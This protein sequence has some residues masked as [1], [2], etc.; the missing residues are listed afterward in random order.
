MHQIK[1]KKSSHPRVKNWLFRKVRRRKR[2]DEKMQP[3]HPLVHLQQTIGNQAVG[4]LIQTQLKVGKPGDKYEQQAD[5]VAETVMQMPDSRLQRQADEEEELRQQPAEEK[6]EENLQQLPEQEEPEKLQRQPEEENKE[7]LHA[8]PAEKEEE[9]KQ[10]PEEKEENE[11]VVSKAIGGHTPIV[12]P[13]IQA[14]IQNMR[15][16]GKPLPS[17]ARNFFEPRFGQ[18]FSRVR[19]HQDTKAAEMA[20]DVKAKAFTVGQ[21]VVFGEGQYDT[22][23]SKGKKLLTHE[24]THVVQQN[25]FPNFIRKTA[26]K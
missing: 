3:D 2:S 10:Q 14:N 6:N 15:G 26:K 20:R 11:T 18:D 9:L 4:R 1:S 19:V 21:D 7:E 5:R 13:K 23:T 12:T 25:A 24:L 22:E 16:G 8:Q 17:S